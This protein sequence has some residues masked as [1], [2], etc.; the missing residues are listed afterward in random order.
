LF[1]DL[2]DGLPIP[3]TLGEALGLQQTQ[4]GLVMTNFEKITGKKE[5]CGV[6][7]LCGSYENYKHYREGVITS[8]T[9]AY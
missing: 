2:S 8:M 6:D 1:I 3:L 5:L 7:M 4:K 9:P